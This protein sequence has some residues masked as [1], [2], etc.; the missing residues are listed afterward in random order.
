MKKHL[1]QI[2]IQLYHEFFVVLPDIMGGEI[3]EPPKG[4]SLKPRDFCLP[5]LV[6]TNSSPWYRWPIEIDRF[7]Y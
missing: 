4:K 3:L 7:T 2:H 1:Y 6:M 5:N